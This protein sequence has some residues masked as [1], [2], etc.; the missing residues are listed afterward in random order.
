RYYFNN[1]GTVPN[2]Y[3]FLIGNITR[4]WQGLFLRAG[5]GEQNGRRKNGPIDFTGGVNP[6]AVTLKRLYNQYKFNWL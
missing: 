1:I 6:I 4:Q 5:K 3:Y 2:L